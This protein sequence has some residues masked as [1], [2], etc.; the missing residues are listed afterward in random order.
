MTTTLVVLNFWLVINGHGA[1]YEQARYPTPQACS[2]AARSAQ[3][4]G[5]TDPLIVWQC[6][7]VDSV[8]NTTRNK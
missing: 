6:V 5:T 1:W 4:S 3:R 2:Q 7:Y 8:L